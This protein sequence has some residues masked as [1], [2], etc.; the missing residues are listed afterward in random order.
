MSGN[1]VFIDTNTAIYLLDGDTSLAAI[2]HHK[3]LYLSFIT[4]LE[5]LGYP[6][7][8]KDDEFQIE[9]MLESSVI[10][11]I[12][13]SIKSEAIRLRRK[14]AIKLPDCI[15]AA[16]AIYLDLPLITTDKGF[17]KLKELNLMLYER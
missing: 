14:Y 10:I 9:N 5:L 8:T 4:Q 11:D 2:L 15:I 16:T 12:N 1:N 3:R 7:V 17:R 13:N 6:G